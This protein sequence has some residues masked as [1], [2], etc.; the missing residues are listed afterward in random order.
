MKDDK[1][2]LLV[3]LLQGEDE[4]I[5]AYG[6]HDE[7]DAGEEV[8]VIPV[9]VFIYYYKSKC[10]FLP[11]FSIVPIKNCIVQLLKPKSNISLAS[12]YVAIFI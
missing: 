3:Y 2:L 9:S 8:F 5:L 11:P 6:S 4:A 12:I 10:L 1:K 7:R